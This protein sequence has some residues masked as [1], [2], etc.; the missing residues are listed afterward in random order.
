MSYQVTS[1]GAP[2]AYPIRPFVNCLGQ[3]LTLHELKVR[4]LRAEHLALIRAIGWFISGMVTAVY[5]L[6]AVRE[7]NDQ[8]E[9]R[10][11]GRYVFYTPVDG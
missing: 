6:K 1:H 8:V 11:L 5:Q 10:R 3:T 4:T 7:K 2:G 9:L